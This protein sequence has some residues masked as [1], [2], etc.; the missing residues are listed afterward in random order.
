MDMNDLFAILNF[1]GT[2]NHSSWYINNSI[3]FKDIKVPVLIVGGKS[4]PIIPPNLLRHL[5]AEL[6]RNDANVEMKLIPGGHV[7]T[8]W[9][10]YEMVTFFLDSH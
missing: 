10:E 3:V 9:R 1:E 6:S 5:R 7:P 8:G 2:N 4:D